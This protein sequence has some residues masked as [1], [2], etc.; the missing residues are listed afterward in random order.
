VTLPVFLDT[1]PTTSK[2]H[3]HYLPLMFD[4]MGAGLLERAR[5]G[6]RPGMYYPLHLGSPYRLSRESSV[7]KNGGG[8]FVYDGLNREAWA[9]IQQAGGYVLID[10]IVESFFGRADMVKALHDGIED[11]G[12]SADRVVLLN[13]NLA[14]ATRY[15]QLTAAM[16]ITE[17]AHVIP[18]DGCFWLV[19][20]HNLAQGEN[21]HPIAARAKRARSLRSTARPKKFVSFN[22]KGRPH[23]TYV[24]LRM[25]ADGYWDKGLISLLGHESDENPSPEAV[26]TQ[27]VRFPQSQRLAPLIPEFLTKL[28]LSVD[29]SREGSRA[30]HAL[31][32]VLPWASPDANAYD[33]TYFSVVLDTSFADEGTVFHT[34]IAYKSYMNFSPFVYFGNAGGLRTLRELGFRSFAPFI[35]ESYDDIVDN[36]QR[37]A[38][39]YAQFERLVNMTDADLAYGL[40][41]VWDA[42]EHNYEFIHRPDL[43]AFARDWNSRVTASLPGAA[44][45]GLDADRRVTG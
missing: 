32:L 14:S 31:K 1:N 29:I 16:G 24:V 33:Q 8:M 21:T 23:R 13:G 44:E 43:E 38:A 10:H 18:Y 7:K 37:M 4:K 42:L 3:P 34:P 28:P 2:Y 20:A 35:D 5:P 6:E 19:K 12:L 36:S 9:Q 41:S 22:G 40:E 15:D 39:A 25:M 17:R 27:I 30:G 26:A 11:A 45:F